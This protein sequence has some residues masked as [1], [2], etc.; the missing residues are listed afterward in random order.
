MPALIE[1]IKGL[2]LVLIAD[3]S[4]EPL[5]DSLSSTGFSATAHFGSHAADWAS[6]RMPTGVNGLMRN[7]GVLRFND[8]IDM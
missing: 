8:T 6:Y 5:G 7:T 3:T 1:S 4:E 2:G